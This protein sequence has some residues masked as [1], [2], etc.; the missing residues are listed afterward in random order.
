MTYRFRCSVHYHHGR[1][2]DSIQVD[3]VL[4][5]ELGVLHF[6]QKANSRRLASRQL[7]EGLK[8][9]PHSDTL[10]PTRPYLLTVPLPIGQA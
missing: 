4:E 1:K 3:M 8:A 2:H 10:P 7:E 5:R 6:V 9:H